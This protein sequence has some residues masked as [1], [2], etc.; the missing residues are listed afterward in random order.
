MCMSNIHGGWETWSKISLANE[1]TGCP[2]GADVLAAMLTEKNRAFS[3]TVFVHVIYVKQDE[4]ILNNY[5][6]I[7]KK[8]KELAG[9]VLLTMVT[10][11]TGISYANRNWQTM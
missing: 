4:H 7:L 10:R 9:N 5:V 2:M 8:N 11:Q 6:F 1:K 3:H